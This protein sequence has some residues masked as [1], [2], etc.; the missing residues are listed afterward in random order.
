MDVCHLLRKS[1][2]FEKKKINTDDET[3]GLINTDKMVIGGLIN[4]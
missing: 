1:Y 3:S 2:K 4:R